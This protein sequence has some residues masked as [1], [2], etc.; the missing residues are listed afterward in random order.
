MFGFLG[1][2]WCGRVGL[3]GNA[4][5]AMRDGILKAVQPFIEVESEEAVEVTISLSFFICTGDMAGSS[6]AAARF[7]YLFYCGS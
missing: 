3:G 4:I 1:L 7:Y 6:Y 5:R 2:Y